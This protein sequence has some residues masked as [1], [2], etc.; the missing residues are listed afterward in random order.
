MWVNVPSNLTFDEFLIKYYPPSSLSSIKEKIIVDNNLTF[1]YLVQDP[2]SIL[3]SY[4]TGQ[5][6]ITNT[7]NSPITIPL[8]TI[9]SATPTVS[10]G[11]TRTYY[12]LAETTVSAVSSVT[13][14]VQATE[15]GNNFNSP[16]NVVSSIPISNLT[17]TNA[18]QIYGGFKRNIL[19]PGDPLW[20]PNVTN[21]TPNMSVKEIQSQGGTD[22]YLTPSGGMSISNNDLQ[23]INGIDTIL[24]D[25][26]STLRTTKGSLWWSKNVGT[27]LPSIPGTPYS[28]SLLRQIEILDEDAAMQNANVKS[29]KATATLLTNTT[30]SVSLDVTLSGMPN[31]LNMNVS[32][33]L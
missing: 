15:Y 1:P 12:I 5:V 28:S 10:G 24:Q 29:A 25:V 27:K 33:S 11:F 4:A 22:I 14:N 18:S 9:V 19:K 26:A 31:S 13:V 2:S 32:K 8:N 17:V 6:T 3:G 30:V 7:T 21:I 23:L 20:L 16:P